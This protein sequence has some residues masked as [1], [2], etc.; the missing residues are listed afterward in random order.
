MA[1]LTCLCGVRD[2]VRMAN[3]SSIAFQGEMFNPN[4]YQVAV[5]PV[6][7]SVDLHAVLVERMSL[8]QR[9]DYFDI[10]AMNS[11]LLWNVHFMAEVNSR[12]KK[13]QEA[14][15]NAKMAYASGV[16]RVLLKMSGATEK[17]R[18]AAA[19][20][21]CEQQLMD[22]RSYE[23]QV[24]ELKA[25]SFTA[26]NSMDALIAVSNNLRADMKVGQL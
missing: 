14:Y 16:N 20:L 19:E 15:K 3:S 12:L 8:F 4:D 13:A 18:Q 7:S 23:A 24:E 2:N 17:A 11:A 9:A 26:K 1:F 25:L 21:V 6:D 5:A 10:Q 22:M